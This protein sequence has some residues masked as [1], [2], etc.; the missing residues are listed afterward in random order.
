MS[1]EF[2]HKDIF[3]TVVDVRLGVEEESEAVLDE[4]GR[5]FNAFSITDAF[6]VKDKKKAWI[7]YQKA[8]LEG[9]SSEEIFFKL[10]W[11]VKSMLLASRTKDAREADMKEFPYN[12][13]KKFLKNFNKEELEQISSDLVTG[14]HQVRRG[15]GDMETFVERVLLSL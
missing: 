8:M 11:Q 3:G 5:E 12:K 13:S 4:K 7:L 2:Y 1:E 9:V 6:G 15:K 10:V 14:Y